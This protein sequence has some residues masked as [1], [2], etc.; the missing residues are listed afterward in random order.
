MQKKSMIKMKE[1]SNRMKPGV[2]NGV[3][4][5]LLKNKIKQTRPLKTTTQNKDPPQHPKKKKMM[6]KVLVISVTLKNQLLNQKNMKNQFKRLQ[7]YP[8]KMMI[9]V[10][11]MIFRKVTLVPR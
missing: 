7:R 11:S 1:R 8:L 5:P 10:T 9:S 3:N 4:K 6:M 2:A